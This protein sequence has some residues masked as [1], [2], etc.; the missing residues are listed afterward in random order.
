MKLNQALNINYTLLSS[1]LLSSCVNVI[2]K[3][4]RKMSKT[5]NETKSSIEFKL[6]VAEFN[7]IVSTQLKCFNSALIYQ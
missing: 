5:S 2:V 4:C 6:H 3:L 1:M 7:I